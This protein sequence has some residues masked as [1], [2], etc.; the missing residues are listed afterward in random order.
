MIFVQIWMVSSAMR[1]TRHDVWMDAARGHA[2][3]HGVGA[4]FAASAMST[5]IDSRSNF[6]AIVGRLCGSIWT[7]SEL[8]G[9]AARNFPLLVSSNLFGAAFG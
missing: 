1:G 7:T 9:V 6:S 3:W 2:A 8:D 5:R 4:A